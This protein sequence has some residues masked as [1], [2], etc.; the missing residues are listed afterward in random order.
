MDRGEPGGFLFSAE[1]FD[2]DHSALAVLHGLNGQRVSEA[3]A[4]N[5]EDL[6][7]ERCHRT[8]RILGEGDKPAMIPLVPRTARTIDLADVNDAKARSCAARTT[9]AS[10]DA[11]LTAGCDRSAKRAGLGIVH[12][13]MLRAAFIMAS[14]MPAYR[15][16]M[17][18]SPLGTPTPRTTT[19]YDRRRQNFDRHAAYV[20]GALVPSG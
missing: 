10:I 11:P 3:C 9:N 7:F 12:P 15:S 17:S 5:V 4:T 19:I 13:H 18:N 20:V 2:H 6:G 14:S 1:H 16:A 8:L